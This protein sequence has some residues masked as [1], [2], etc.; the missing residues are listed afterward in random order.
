MNN[1]EKLSDEEKSYNKWVSENLFYINQYKQSLNVMK[2]IYLD[3]FAAGWQFKK[4][5]TATEWLEK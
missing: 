4:E 2:K 3:G 1:E 5:Y